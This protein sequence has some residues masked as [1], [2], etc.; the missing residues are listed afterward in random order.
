MTAS[1]DGTR[2]NPTDSRISI[3]VER[4]HF[5]DGSVEE[6]GPTEIVVI[7]GP[8]S[9]GKSKFLN[10]LFHAVANYPS[11]P[12]YPGWI[13]AIDLNR[14]GSIEQLDGWFSR[15]A[16]LYRQSPEPH[17]AIF[18]HNGAQLTR[19]AVQKAW[20]GSTFGNI[21]EFMVKYLPARDRGAIPLNNRAARN[22]VESPQD[23]IH[24][25]WDSADDERAFSK[26]VEHAFGFGVSI[27][28]HDRG[29]C[30]L[31]KGTPRPEYN[32]VIPTGDALEWYAK[33]SPLDEEGD[34][35]RAFVGILLEAVAGR[36]LMTIIDEPETFL[37]PR[38]QKLI[39][40]Y[41]AEET[42]PVGQ[43]FIAT[44]SADV[45]QGVLDAHG[46]RRVKIIRLE[47]RTWRYTILPPDRV[48]RLWS[49]PLLRYS[50]MLDGLFHRGLIMC[51]A[52]N[53]SRF[54]E[55][56]MDTHFSSS[57]DHDLI[58]THLDGKSRFAAALADL[59]AFGIPSAVIG[60]IDVLRESNKLREL[61][62]A[63][64]GDYAQIAAKVKLVNDEIQQMIGA[65]T[66]GTLR[67]VVAPLLKRVA[68]SAISDDESTK[69]KEALKTRSGWKHV[70]LAGVPALPNTA[71]SALEV[72]E[73]LLGLGIFLVP[74]GELESWY[75]GH[76]TRKGAPYVTKI[77]EDRRH[78]NPPSHLRH[79]LEQ[80]ATYFEVDP[81]RD[82]VS[83]A[84][85]DGCRNL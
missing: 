3:A 73:F 69:I 68:A 18:K 42:G 59:R 66:V 13:S 15:R 80:L 46:G 58:I 47:P 4:V 71:G 36:P 12:Q 83:R 82:Q 29:N 79:F 63:A 53:D 39:G 30:G 57:F 60:D 38:Q 50:R 9:A 19:E 81:P 17:Y 64:G 55:A 32:D 45:L 27:N 35:V 10:E 41:L 34:G 25:L 23:S 21:Q 43:I 70:K 14:K 37:H 77:L 61:V 31:L 2:S 24:Y 84:S 5:I 67:N 62:E 26:L 52:D 40:R 44:H 48:R 65:P 7:V 6:F 72:L 51:E 56:H 22:P 20:T 16:R 1:I 75:I 78:E 28:R 33:L 11:P 8:N 54:Y 74:C 85:I 76:E 49:D